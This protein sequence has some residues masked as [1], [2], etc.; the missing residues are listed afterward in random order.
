MDYKLLYV[1]TIRCT[2]LSCEED[3]AVYKIVRFNENEL[4]TAD[5]KYLRKDLM[6]LEK[7]KVDKSEIIIRV[8]FLIKE[9]AIV[10]VREIF[11]EI[12]KN[13]TKEMSD[14]VN[15]EWLKILHPKYDTRW[16]TGGKTVKKW[17]EEM[18]RLANKL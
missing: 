4:Y 5:R 3:L 13:G 14:L 16:F 2:E 7:I 8:P 6:E 11:L 9:A 1:L 15:E 12:K 10:W 18:K 17:G